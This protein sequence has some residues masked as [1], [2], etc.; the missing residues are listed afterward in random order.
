M[1]GSGRWLPAGDRP[2]RGAWLGPLSLGLSLLSWP[3]PAG[4][5]AVAVVAVGF[6]VLSMSTQ[7]QY[8]VD[9]TAVVGLSIGLLQLLLSLML[10]VMTTNGH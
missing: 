9:W 4:G 6:G 10:L 7:T 2:G 3:I 1:N 5:A 8:R